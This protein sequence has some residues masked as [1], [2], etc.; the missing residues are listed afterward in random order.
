MLPKKLKPLYPNRKGVVK[1]FTKNN[2]KFPKSRVFQTR[3]HHNETKSSLL[4][5]TQ[6]EISASLNTLDSIVYRT[7]QE[8]PSTQ[9]FF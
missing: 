8:G 3:C 2:L 5:S 6:E 7:T 1:F 9:I 4:P